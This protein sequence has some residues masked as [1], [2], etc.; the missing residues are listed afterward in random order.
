MRPW[1]TCS[2]TSAISL[3]ATDKISVPLSADL[4]DN[5]TVV[6][7]R[8]K[9]ARVT[10]QHRVPF[11]DEDRQRSDAGQGCHPDHLSRSTGHV[12]SHLRHRLCRR[13]IGRQDRGISQTAASSDHP[14]A[15]QRN[16][17][18]ACIKYLRYRVEQSHY[19]QRTDCRRSQLRP[20]VLPRRWSPPGVGAIAI[21]PA[22]LPCGTTRWLAGERN[23]SLHRG[24]WNPQALPGS[25]MATVGPDWQTNP[26]DADHLGAEL[27]SGPIRNTLQ[28]L[29][30]LE[31]ALAGL[32]LTTENGE[33]T[34]A[35][36][37]ILDL[38]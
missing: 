34:T 10:E 35:P 29:G 7:K 38:L 22:W 6:I 3:G 2:R 37:M 1:P 19:Q 31:F 4:T 30:L 14:A 9:N 11:P 36:E 5:M 15:A 27:H 17:A 18:A 33:P 28:R 26:S 13:Q 21:S 8:V 16:Q 25:K 12:V 32:V 23:E 20:R 24:V